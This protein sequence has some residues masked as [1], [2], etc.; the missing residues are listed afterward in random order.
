MALLNRLRTPGLVFAAAA[1]ATLI[2]GPLSTS[3]S[4]SA[5]FFRT[6]ENRQAGTQLAITLTKANSPLTFVPRFDG[7]AICATCGVPATPA[8]QAWAEK[9]AL[10][11]GP[12]QSISLVNKQTGK[13]AD[14]EF[15]AQRAGASAIGAKV[16]L[17]PCDGTFSQRWDNLF[18]AAG[19]QS[20]YRNRLNQLI[21]T[22][23][24]SSVQL[25]PFSSQNGVQTFGSTFVNVV[26]Q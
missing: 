13:C 12:D 10:L 15:S 23:T 16:V 4:A 20:K 25:Q 26:Q 9:R 8:K 2:T 21:L 3:A 22:S 18:A 17:A 5:T 19:N 24:G 7:V 11:T 6:V 1:V 14:V